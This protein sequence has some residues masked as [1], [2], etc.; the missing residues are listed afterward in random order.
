MIGIL[1]DCYRFTIKEIPKF[2]MALQIKAN[3]VKV[4]PGE[5]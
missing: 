1:L 3:N 2:A 5:D 4:M